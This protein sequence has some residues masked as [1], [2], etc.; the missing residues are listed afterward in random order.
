CCRTLVVQPRDQYTK[1]VSLAA[2]RAEADTERGTILFIE[3]DAPLGAIQA[4]VGD[5]FYLDRTYLPAAV[6]P[7]LHIVTCLQFSE[8][9]RQAPAHDAGHVPIVDVGRRDLEVH[10]VD[11]CDAIALLETGLFRGTSRGDGAD[12]DA[13]RVAPTSGGRR[14]P[15][16]G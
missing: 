10:A 6:H 2:A 3:T 5:G 15:D 7:Q 12:Q 4:V 9:A 14:N 16:H 13:K 1:S 8:L 11:G